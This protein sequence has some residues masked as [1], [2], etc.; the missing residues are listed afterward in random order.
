MIFE[1]I[2]HYVKLILNISELF[3]LIFINVTK[4]A[5]VAT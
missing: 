4:V 1:K 3:N 2:R 5:A